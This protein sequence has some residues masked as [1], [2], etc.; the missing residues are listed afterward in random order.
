LAYLA[1]INTLT[2]SAKD[3]VQAVQNFKAAA[4]YDITNTKIMYPNNRALSIANAAIEILDEMQHFYGQIDTGNN[5][6]ISDIINYQR[7]KITEPDTHSYSRIVNHK[8]KGDFAA[9][10][11]YES[12]KNRNKNV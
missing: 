1:S 6:R 2:L 11:L 3:Q 7:Q 5:V 4:H 9:K 10:T 12:I 8:F